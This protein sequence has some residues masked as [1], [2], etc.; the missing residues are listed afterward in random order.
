MSEG[1][2]MIKNVLP[3]SIR[4]MPQ[5]TVFVSLTL[6]LLPLD[7]TTSETASQAHKTFSAYCFECHLADTKNEDVQLDYLDCISLDAR[8]DLLNKVQEHLCIKDMPPRKGKDQPSAQGKHHCTGLKL[9][10]VI[11]AGDKPKPINMSSRYT[12]LTDYSQP[13]IEP[14][15]NF[16]TTLSAYGDKMKH[17]G[18]PNVGLSIDQ[19]GPIPQSST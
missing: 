5:R 7:L 19:K 1:K 3:L 11:V 13:A 17:H 12:R 15:L 4:V 9:S 2:Q 18:D 10:F 16:T 14:W 8:M 6:F